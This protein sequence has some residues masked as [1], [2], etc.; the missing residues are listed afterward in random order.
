MIFVLKYILIVNYL[1]KLGSLKL[2][3]PPNENLATY[4]PISIKPSGT[5]CGLEL[6]DTLCNN[7]LLDDRACSNSSS[8]FY[9]DQSCPYGNVLRNLYKLE[10][11]KLELMNPCVVL[12]DHKYLL[13]NSSPANSY[14][15]DGDNDVCNT[16]NRIILWRPFS[17]ESTLSKPELSFFNSRTSG[18]FVV[19]SGLTFTLWFKQ[20][21]LN[22]GYLSILSINL[23]LD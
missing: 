13:T 22:N 14:Y 17:L 1:I 20:F 15:F 11:L 4:K 5:T 19:N 3:Y 12:K 7:L 23:N 9:C 8:L 16:A 18:L 21:D 2:L 10:Q 6:K